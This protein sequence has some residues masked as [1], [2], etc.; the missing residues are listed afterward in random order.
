MPV[1]FW[2]DPDGA[3][4]RRAY[5]DFF[6]GVWRHGDWAE[7][8]PEGGMII[9]GRSDATLNPGGV[10]IGTAEIYRP[11]EQLDEIVECVAVGQEIPLG[12]GGG[13]DVRVVLFVRLRPGVTLDETLRDAVRRRIREHTTA[14]HVPKVIVQVADIPRTVSGKISEIAVR[15]AIHGRA[16]RNL[17]ALANLRRCVMLVS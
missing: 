12:A 17:D 16:V 9:H 10:R 6:P 11:V 5:F 15:E 14:H 3:N 1:R 2:N 7:L 13:S 4:Y 8:T